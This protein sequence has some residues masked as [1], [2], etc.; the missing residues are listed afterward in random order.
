MAKECRYKTRSRSE[1]IDSVDVLNAD[2]E[3]QIADI[4]LPSNISQVFQSVKADIDLQKDIDE[5]NQLPKIK[6]QK[7]L[8]FLNSKIVASA[9]QEAIDFFIASKRNRIW[10]EVFEDETAVDAIEA[11][12]D[13]GYGRQVR[14]Q[15]LDEYYQARDMVI[16]SGWAFRVNG[17]ITP[18]NLMQKLAAVHLRSQQR[19][20]NLSLT[21][22]GKTIGGILSSRIIDAHLTI[23]ICPLDTVPNWH[24]EIKHVFPDSLVTIKN[25]NPHWV[26]IEQGHH[27][28]LFNHEMFQQPSTAGNI[29]QLLERY[30]IDLVIVDEIHRCKQRSEDPSK[31]RQ[32]VLALIT[33]AAEK[34]PDLHVLGMSATPVI[35]NLREGKSL[36]EL[37]TGVERLDLGEK[38]TINNCMR[39]HQ[40]FVTLGI[41]SK[42][43]PKIKIER[44]NVP[45]E[46]THL[47]D[48]IR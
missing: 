32:M 27:Y 23:I 11:F 29:R 42:V 3:L 45:V 9:D 48:R 5:S 19:M 28:I 41:R 46:C 47:V 17:K 13:D 31:R 33:N 20:L 12:T 8:E 24:R 18:P 25:F 15:F 40:A 2:T 34:N 14:D 22:T 35:N 44:V 1:A 36:V 10:A 38:A 21:G 39:L 6:V 30:Q 43:K 16:P 37:V 26:D 4:T 7:S